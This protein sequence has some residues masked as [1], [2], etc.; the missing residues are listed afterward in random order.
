MQI[1]K[2]IYNY[3]NPITPPDLD[4]RNHRIVA[5]NRVP[6]KL[7]K[8]WLLCQKQ[9]CEEKPGAFKYESPSVSKINFTKVANSHSKSGKIGAYFF[10]FLGGRSFGVCHAQGRRPTMEDQHITNTFNIKIGDK[11]YPVELYGVFDGHGGGGA[12]AYIKNNLS[13]K[14]KEK[15]LEL[16]VDGLTEAG[17]FNALKLAFVAVHDDF[18]SE[19]VF[20][21]KCI[22]DPSG[23]TATVSM[24]LDGNL[25]TANTGDSRTILQDGKGITEQ[26]SE[27]AKPNDPRYRRS[28]KKRGG[29][30]LSIHGVPRINGNLAVGRGIGDYSVGPGIN[31]RPKITKVALSSISEGSKLILACDGIYDVANTQQVGNAVKEH[32]KLSNEH[33]AK[34][35]VYSAYQAHS[36]DNLSALVVDIGTAKDRGLSS[37][38]ELLLRFMSFETPYNKLNIKS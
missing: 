27:D 21:Q 31:P 16:N 9:M 15:L 19:L 12:S 11:E 23:T 29:C 22:R 37:L 1:I 30:V 3:F 18:E 7:Q 33:L 8:Q 26:L 2:S 4:D 34:G 17:I 28:I 13:K 6:D 38:Q 25:W 5:A 10:N 32:P 36:T 14:L 20:G 24:I 35:I